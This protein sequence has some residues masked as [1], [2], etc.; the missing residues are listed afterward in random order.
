MQLR[1][2]SDWEMFALL[3]V[4]TMGLPAPAWCRKNVTVWPASPEL[5]PVVSKVAAIV[6]PPV[7][8][9]VPASVTDATYFPTI[10]AAGRNPV[11]EFVG[12]LS[13]SM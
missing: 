11:V 5:T 2:M 9:A 10:D 1:G 7:A 4:Q 6:Q 13:F 8:L 3:Q 12:Q